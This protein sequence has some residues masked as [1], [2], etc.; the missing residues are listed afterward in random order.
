MA[1]KR[2]EPREK[3]VQRCIGFNFRQVEFFNEYPEFKPDEY[4]RKI[5]DEQIKQ[6]NKKFLKNEA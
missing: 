3:I 5:V 1:K 6:V 4:C 2:V